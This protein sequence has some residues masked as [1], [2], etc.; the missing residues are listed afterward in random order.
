MHYHRLPCLLLLLGGLLFGCERDPQRPAE[1]PPTEPSVADIEERDPEREAATRAAWQN[2]SHWL[3]QA[4]EACQDM[5]QAIE[6]FLSDPAETTQA[7]ARAQW[8]ECHDQWH[9]LDPLFA[10]SASNPGL[11]GQ[12]QQMTFDIEARP[13]QPGYL[14][15]L[16]DYPF[17]GI[18]NDTTVDITA[19]AL[20]EQ[21]GLTDVSD[22]SLG[23]HALEFLLWGERGQRP[24]ADYEPRQTLTQ[25][26]REAELSLDLLPNNRRRELLRL[27]SHL[28]QDD[29]EQLQDY[30]DSDRNTLRLTYR[31]LDPQSRLHLLKDAA[32]QLLE[33]QLV[34][35]L[36]GLT[37]PEAGHNRFAGEALRPLLSA[38]VG[39]RELL[40]AG[41]PPVIQFLGAEQARTEWQSQLEEVIEQVRSQI[42]SEDATDTESLVQ[43]LQLLGVFLQ[44]AAV[45]P[46]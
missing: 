2:G 44:P 43:R 9:R 27:L 1:P 7:S 25:A 46:A 16:E 29:L 11:F 17:S 22:V 8:H 3:E 31:R 13:L 23:L 45:P 33:Q 10:L 39:L 19:S 42:E 6:T 24:V 35:D 15:S 34:T 26:Q 4:G 14:D 41:E 28:L 36:Q 21:H 32:R 12:L 18:V 40:T 37:D 38:L 20:R 5:H 30:W